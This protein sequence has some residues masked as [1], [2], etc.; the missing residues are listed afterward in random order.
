MTG[1]KGRTDSQAGGMQTMETQ[2]QRQ[3][4]AAEAEAKFVHGFSASVGYFLPL[5]HRKL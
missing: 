3:R 4:K 1:S 2:L 5:C